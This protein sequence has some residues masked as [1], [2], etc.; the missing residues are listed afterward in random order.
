MRLLGR[1]LLSSALFQTAVMVISETRGL[2]SV[3]VGQA[4]ILAFLRNAEP[5]AANR[6][7]IVT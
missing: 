5:S 6:W 4:G 1:F 7:P 2:Q 3:L